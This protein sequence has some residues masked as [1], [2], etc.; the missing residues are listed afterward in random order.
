MARQIRIKL[1]AYDY[2]LIDRAA[3]EIVSA[4]ER[5][6]ADINGPVPLPTDVRR[7]TV[8]KAPHKF[9]QGKEQF[10]LRTHKRLIDIENPNND[11]MNALSQLNLT[12]G[13]DVQIKE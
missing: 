1:K 4:A 8:N 6:G 2:R 7:Y 11:T 13:V 3:S 9:E 12:A 10:E 5:T